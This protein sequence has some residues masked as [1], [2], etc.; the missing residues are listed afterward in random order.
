MEILEKAEIFGCP[1]LLTMEKLL[2]QRGGLPCRLS[3]TY[4]S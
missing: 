3:V 4:N 1:G 2:G